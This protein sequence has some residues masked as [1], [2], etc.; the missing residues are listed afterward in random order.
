MNDDKLIPVS[1]IKDE[2]QMGRWSFS[3]WTEY[4][5]IKIIK[6]WRTNYCT[7]SDYLKLKE[8]CNQP[9]IGNIKRQI[10]EEH[11]LKTCV[12]RYGGNSPMSSPEVVNKIKNTCMKKYGV[13]SVLK[14]KK[15]REKIND[16]L[17]G[18]YGTSTISNIPGV[19]EKTKKTCLKRYGVEYSAQSKQMI[20][21]AKRTKTE[22]YGN[23][24]YNNR[25]KC[26]QTCLKKYGKSNVKQVDEVKEKGVHTCL[27]KY[28]V[29]YYTQ[30]QDMKNKSEQTCMKNYGVRKPTQSK[31]VQE[32]M[33][34][35]IFEHYG[36]E[37]ALQ[38]NDILR[39]SHKKWEV[40]G[41]S[42]ISF[43]SK[44][45]AY[46]YVYLKDHNYKF[47][48]QVE[49]PLPY[50]DDDG[51]E[52]IFIVDFKVDDEYIEIKGN[53]FFDSEGNPKFIY[54]KNNI[55][56]NRKRLRLWELKLDVIKSNNDIKLVLSKSFNKGGD[57]F[58]MK[59]YF[60]KNYTFIKKF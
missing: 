26:K 30:T 28:G 38:S 5:G 33:K 11:R 29:K 2:L 40:C 48:Y 3:T 46:F 16:V 56:D 44:E 39:K 49:Y 43:A 20:E 35:T 9:D 41:L 22:R 47:E 37:H 32:K 1:L 18:K 27:E 36:V 23:S 52:H 45:E 13:E 17:I 53:Q 54:N 58:Y 50:K 25:E 51:Q 34:R 19:K 10:K 8:F 12:E 15:I 24:G 4:L 60:N 55:D 6:L 31:E 57:Y 21:N 59:E 42:N 14:D 7:K